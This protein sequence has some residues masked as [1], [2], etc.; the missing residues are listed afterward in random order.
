M[1]EVSGGGRLGNQIFRSLAVSI[2]AEKFNLKSSYKSYAQIKELGIHLFIGNILHCNMIELTDDNY[3][4]ILN[5]TELTTNLNP[6][7]SFFQ[8]KDISNFL[9]N[10]LQSDQ[11]K[12][13]IINKNPNINRYN[14][15]NDLFIHIRLGDV[16]Q[17]N[18]GIN[19]YLK[20]ISLIHFN[21]MYISSDSIDHNIIKEIMNKYPQAIIILKDEIKTIQFA[22]TCKHI[23][24]S[25]GSFSA[26]IGYL[27]F[28]SQIYYP[29]YDE[30]YIW[31]GD[32]FS[33]NGWNKIQ[34]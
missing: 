34:F 18:P 20:A 25:H 30:K 1:T 15:N 17:Y 11:I 4:N 27:S 3:F 33:I 28:Y 9:Y 31:Y 26:I 32:M 12:T 10:Y 5:N 2:I 8:T 21:N 6:N 13:K 16:I 19:Y 23:I 7:N 22:S 24:L 29:Q 14:N